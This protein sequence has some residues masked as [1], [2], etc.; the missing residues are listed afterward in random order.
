MATLCVGL[1]VAVLQV[2]ETLHK[3]VMQN[4]FLQQNGTST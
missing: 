1:P 3:A 4:D 2:N